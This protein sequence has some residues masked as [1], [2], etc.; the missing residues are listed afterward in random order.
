MAAREP[1]HLRAPLATLG[2]TMVD[3]ESPPRARA[4]AV[5]VRS[6]RSMADSEDLPGTYGPGRLG[7]LSATL[8]SAVDPPNSSNSPSRSPGLPTGVSTALSSEA[9]ATHHRRA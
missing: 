1:S 7:T 4:L 6:L 3:S 8:V 9:N 2:S 5:T